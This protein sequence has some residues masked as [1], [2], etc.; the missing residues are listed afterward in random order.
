MRFRE[1]N[2]EVIVKDGISTKDNILIK[3]DTPMKNTTDL[4]APATTA[5]IGM[6]V[7][8]MTLGVMFVWTFFENLGKGLYS[9]EGYAGLISSYISQRATP[10][11]SGK[12]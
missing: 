11:A 1:K 3:D 10:Q 5:E 12:L 9:P 4:P 6:A 7:L 2:Q 8:R